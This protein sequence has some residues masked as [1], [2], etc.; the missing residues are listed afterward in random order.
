MIQNILVLGAGS[1]GLLAAI[2]LKM[3]LPR[4]GVRLVRSSSL[5]AA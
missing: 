5:G 4:L 2:S 3:K 1:A